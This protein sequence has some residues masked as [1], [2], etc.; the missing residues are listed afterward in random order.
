MM[1]RKDFSN[2]SPTASKMGSSLGQIM[3]EK[4]IPLET[5]FRAEGVQARLRIIS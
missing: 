5:Y 1:Y 3:S 2:R 4:H